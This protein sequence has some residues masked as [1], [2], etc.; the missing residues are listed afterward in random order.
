MAEP[1]VA[2]PVSV[3]PRPEAPPQKMEEDSS[4]RA[5]L[6]FTPPA[7]AAYSVDPLDA[8]AAASAP[9]TPPARDQA[10][11]PPEQA[12][13]STANGG[14]HIQ[15]TYLAGLHEG[16]RSDSGFDPYADP[17]HPGTGA[18]EPRPV[19]HVPGRLSGHPGPLGGAPHLVHGEG[20][21]PA[22]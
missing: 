6:G 17:V 7:P 20:D 4:E 5:G 11:E 21:G 9:S 8:M 14:T 10:P 2:W 12:T 3:E 15:D 22:L 19:C 18:R 16:L 1:P 13:G